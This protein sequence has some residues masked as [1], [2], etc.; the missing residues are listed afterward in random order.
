MCAPSTD[1]NLANFGDEMDRK[2]RVPTETERTIMEPHGFEREKK[3]ERKDRSF[4][5]SR[6][7][8]GAVYDECEADHWIRL[9]S[10][11]RSTAHNHGSMCKYVHLHHISVRKHVV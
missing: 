4:W 5:R 8:S 9:F 1:V 3:K 2:P 11:R 7:T 10:R 6:G